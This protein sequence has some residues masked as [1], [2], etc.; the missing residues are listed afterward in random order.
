[1]LALYRSGRQ[2]DALRA[3]QEARDVLV[4]ELGIEPGPELRS[5]E[6][7]ILAQDPDLGWHAPS[8]GGNAP[9]AVDE[10]PS[11]TFVGRTHERAR[12]IGRLG[13]VQA[14]SG[15]LVLLSGE[16][17][18]G[19]TRLCEQLSSY[20]RS[21]NMRVV[22]ARGW[23]GDGAPAFWPWVQVLRTLA[24]Q[25]PRRRVRPHAMRG[26]GAD[27]ARVVPDYAALRNRRRRRARCRVG[28]LP[29]LRSRR[30]AAAQ[31]LGPA[32]DRHRARR[33]ALGRPELTAVVGVRRQRVAAVARLAGRHVP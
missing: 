6:E 2:A 14:A 20:A 8:A 5:L 11:A 33:P 18:I 28:A 4:E 24:E 12:L 17:G 31:P 9:V 22:W 16:P 19:K 27:I 10:A 15:R 29:L 25:T 30:V 1:M 7:K 32:S 21:Q 23:E 13:E 26:S 3:Y